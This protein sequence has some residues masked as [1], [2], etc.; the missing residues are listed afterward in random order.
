MS[1]EKTKTKIIA[2]CNQKGGVGKT[3]TV[4]NLGAALANAKMKVLII[5]LDPQGNASTGYGIETNDRENT[6]YDVLVNHEIITKTIMKTN[7]EN[8]DIICSDVNLSAAEVELLS[9]ENK[10]R[11]L[12]KSL[13]RVVNKYD[14]I[15]IDC[16]PSFGQL[17]INALTAANCVIVPMQCEFYALEG[18]SHLMNSIKLIQKNLNKELKI[19]GILLTMY[20]KRYNLTA[21]V[22]NDVREILSDLVFETVI[23]RNVRIS[24]APSHGLPVISYDSNSSGAKSYH[25]LAREV[26]LRLREI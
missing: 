10:E 8:L 11:K 17:T 21:Q 7:F 20:D 22:E 25:D 14:Y 26:V 24:E 1:E 5:D 16:P 2:I 4:V 18:L 19:L 15:L 13:E 12:K 6:I 9:I 23:P 3:T